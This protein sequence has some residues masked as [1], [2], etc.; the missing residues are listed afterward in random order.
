MQSQSASNGEDIAYKDLDCWVDGSPAVA[1]MC[2]GRKQ[3]DWLLNLCLR[4]C[5][6]RTRN[7]SLTILLALG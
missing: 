5:H 7:S 4:L 2:I 6:A 1:R 3:M